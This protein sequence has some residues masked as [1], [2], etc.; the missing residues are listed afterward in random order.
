MQSFRLLRKVRVRTRIL[1]LLLAGSFLSLGLVLGISMQ[2]SSNIASSYVSDY[3][4]TAHKRAANSLSLYLEE[5]VLISLRYKND[6]KVYTIV[7]S[8]EIPTQTQQALTEATANILEPDATSVSNV[9]LLAS[10]GLVYSLRQTVL[11]EQPLDTQFATKAVGQPYAI[12]GQRVRDTD[13]NNHIAVA[14]EY[15]S[16]STGRSIGSLILLLPEAAISQNNNGLLTTE[17]YSFVVDNHKFVVSAEKNDDAIV[18]A[19]CLPDAQMANSTQSETV[20][21]NGK[22]CLLVS[23]SVAQS[24]YNIGFPWQIVSVIPYDE[25]FDVLEQVRSVLIFMAVFII[26]G[27]IIVSLLISKRL[28]SPL[29]HLQKNMQALSSGQL[30]S[31]VEEVANDEIWELEQGYNEMVW[32]INELIEKNQDEQEKKREMEFIALQAQINPHFLYNTLDAIGWMA[33]LKGQEEIEQ[34]VMALSRFF[35]LSLHKGAKRITVA[36]ELG[37]TSSYIL[38]EQLRNPGRFE[39]EYKVD[40]EVLGYL[41]PK[42]VLQPVV[43]NAVKHGIAQVRRT[44]HIL[45]SGWLQQDDIYLRVEDNGAGFDATQGEFSS[46]RLG[47]GYGLKNVQERIQLEF[48]EDYGLYVESTIGEGTVTTLRL[49][50]LAKTEIAEQSS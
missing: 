18:A 16:F 6:G 43:E 12:V 20:Q 8:G 39:V 48:G 45:I 25:A 38:I 36:D 28:T 19:S 23:T 13:G 27:A 22:K 3:L 41:I 37:I 32:R 2:Y 40:D 26:V 34:I 11:L 42:I 30:D 47:N 35:R 1:L 14:L 9:Y 33:K 29:K 4:E 46:G 7:Q 21:L 24:T 10:D 31:F 17:G 44:G 49:K 50:A 15:R 5:V